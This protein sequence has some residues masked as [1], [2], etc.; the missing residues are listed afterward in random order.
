MFGKNT[1][2]APRSIKRAA[3]YIRVSTEEQAMHGYSLEAQR[4]SLT[5]Y[6]KENNL[7]IVD[8]YID[9]GK[10][11]RRK[12]QNRKEFARMMQDVEAGKIDIILFIKLDRWFRSVKDYYKV[13]EI[14]E[15]HGVDWKTTEEHYDTSTTN[16]RLY[17]NIRLSVAQD[18]SDRDS[19]RIKFVFDSKVARSEA[20]YGAQSLP[21]GL[22]VRDK[23][24]VPDPDKIDIVRDIF[25]HY[26]THHVLSATRR[27]ALDTYGLTFY[28]HG[29]R[30]MLSN[31]LYIG[32]YRDNP[33]YCAPIVDT[34]L[35]NRVQ[36]ALPKNV[37]KAPTGRIYIFSGLVVCA[38][39]G[40][41]MVGSYGGSG[42]GNFYYR[43]NYSKNLHICAHRKTIGERPLENWVLENIESKLEAYIAAYNAHAAKRKKPQSDKAKIRRKLSKLKELYLNDLISMDEYKADF[44]T[45]TAQLAELEEPETPPPNLKALSDFLHSDFKGIYQDLGR[46]DRR[47]LWLSII[48]EIRI[49]AQNNIEIFFA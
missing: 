23:H 12:L 43:C 6:A 13:Q 15:A 17:I 46:E 3:L 2:S 39:C 30:T 18:E 8:Y 5:K 28:D 36:A 7:A 20:I 25:N 41:R 21:F 27:Y 32:Q 22:M 1:P 14:L 44:D 38:E 48:K 40:H 9:E 47:S 10:S 26:A 31:P 35:F 45:Y 16:G 29:F 33:N 19:D 11:A 37:R 49:D 4:E 34:E 42:H 24:V